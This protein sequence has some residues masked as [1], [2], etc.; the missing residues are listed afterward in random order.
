MSFVVAGKA[1]QRIVTTAAVE[2]VGSAVAGDR[3]SLI[4]ADDLLDPGH[5]I[6]VRRSHRRWNQPRGR[7]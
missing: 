6:G 1:V 3:V 4:G 2:P 7:H 5:R